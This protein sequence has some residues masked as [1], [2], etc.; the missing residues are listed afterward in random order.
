MALR[1]AQGR[2]EAEHARLGEPVF[3]V[4]SGAGAPE[5]FSA[6][7]VLGGRWQ[8]AASA[9]CAADME[10]AV[11][12]KP[13]PKG[14]APGHERRDQLPEPRQLQGFGRVV[15]RGFDALVAKKP[16]QRPVLKPN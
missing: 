4:P 7:E 5:R 3:W 1:A 9:E 13:G 6:L 14:V 8:A 11:P 15:G 12:R 16:A 2:L 10:G